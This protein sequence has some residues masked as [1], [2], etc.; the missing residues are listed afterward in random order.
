VSI[1]TNNKVRELIQ[2]WG[3]LVRYLPPYSPNYNPI[4]LTFAV[5]KAWIKQ[6]YL[7]VQAR[8]GG[9][10]GAFL[11]AAVHKSKC[12]RFAQ[13]HFK[14][15]AGGLYIKQEELDRVRAEIRGLERVGDFEVD[16]D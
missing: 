16:E 5:L 15:A 7:Y 6:N 3:Y 11:R 14:Y 10:F 8:F 2:R 9:N 12:D 1:H 4:K 13:K